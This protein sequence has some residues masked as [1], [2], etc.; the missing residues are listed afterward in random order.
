MLDADEDTA[1]VMAVLRPATDVLRTTVTVCLG[2]L[3]AADHAFE[4]RNS[5][6]LSQST[7]DLGRRIQA[8]R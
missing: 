4:R 5:L 1:I 6:Y 7:A 3:I 8:Q 2:L